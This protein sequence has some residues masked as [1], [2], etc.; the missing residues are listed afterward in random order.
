[1]PTVDLGEPT[2]CHSEPFRSTC[3]DPA[4][5]RSPGRAEASP[6]PRVRSNRPP[7]WPRETCGL[8]LKVAALSLARAPGPGLQGPSVDKG[9]GPAGEV[10]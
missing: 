3:L 4:K 8:T 5:D 1:M 9:E 2:G 6:G 7:V 10:H